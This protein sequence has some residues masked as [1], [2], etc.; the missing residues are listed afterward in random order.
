M[1]TDSLILEFMAIRKKISNGMLRLISSTLFKLI[2][3]LFLL[4][5][6]RYFC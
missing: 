5:L 1:K 6:K 2:Q 4:E 3:K